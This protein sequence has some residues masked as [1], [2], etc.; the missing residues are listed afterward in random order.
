MLKLLEEEKQY[1]ILFFA[2]ENPQKCAMVQTLSITE[3]SPQLQDRQAEKLQ[4]FGLM[5]HMAPKTTSEF[6]KLSKRLLKQELEKLKP[7]IAQ[8]LEAIA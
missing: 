5:G 3:P 6:S 7:T 1:R 8:K 2:K 4:E